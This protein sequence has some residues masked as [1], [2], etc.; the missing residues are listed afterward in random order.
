MR[1][2]GFF[3]AN[4]RKYPPYK[5]WKKG[6]FARIDRHLYAP[7]TGDEKDIIHYFF[8]EDELKKILSGF[9]IV[10]IEEDEKSRHFCVL[11]KKS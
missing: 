4:L 8:A 10:K 11:A 3:F 6:K 9:S 7:T 1:T 2:G 5:D